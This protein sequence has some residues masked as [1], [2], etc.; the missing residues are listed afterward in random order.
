MQG[1][2]RRQDGAKHRD[3]HPRLEPRLDPAG[4]DDHVVEILPALIAHPVTR[5]LEHRRREQALEI[6]AVDP[7]H[8]HQADAVV[9]DEVVDVDQV[10]LLDLRDPDGDAGH[11]RHRLVVAGG[12][13]ITGG[14]EDLQGH[15]QREL[16]GPEP[17]AEVDDPLSPR[18]QP[19]PQPVRLDPRQPRLVQERPVSVRQ[20]AR[21]AAL[22]AGWRG[23][24]VEDHRHSS[25][26][27]A[28]GRRL[29]RDPRKES[30]PRPTVVPAREKKAGSICRLPAVRTGGAAK[31]KKTCA[32]VEVASR[33]SPDKI[34]CPR[35]L[36][37]PDAPKPMPREF[38]TVR[39]RGNG[40]PVHSIIDAPRP[41]C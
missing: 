9:L 19:P 13:V 3:R 24:I 12:A 14:R 6:V 35:S 21:R 40:F 17:L 34:A 8:L 16:V 10:V 4:R 39:A 26:V 5:P 28:Q 29:H 27:V 2:Q 37:V 36:I 15:R 1:R 20:V 11:A 18:P 25:V 31:Q 23:V 33:A 7:L 41:A 30:S 38:G 32:P 22:G